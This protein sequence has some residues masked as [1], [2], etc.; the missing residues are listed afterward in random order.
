MKRVNLWLLIALICNSFSSCGDIFDSDQDR[1]YT[2]SGRVVKCEGCE[3]LCGVP[4]KIEGY[5]K[6]FGGVALPKYIEDIAFDT[7][8]N[9]GYFILNYKHNSDVNS[10][11]YDSSNEIVLST[12]RVSKWFSIKWH[13]DVIDTII[14]QRNLHLVDTSYLNCG[15]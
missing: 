9:D 2:I 11:I 14:W 1:I 7:T 5:Q 13:R 15:Q 10:K 12:S 8:D 3:P 6:V 4:L